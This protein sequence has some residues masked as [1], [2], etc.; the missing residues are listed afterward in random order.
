[1]Q[2]KIELVLISFLG[3]FLE[4]SFIRWL[5]AHIFSIAFFS[6]VILI[7]SFLGLGLGFLL[8]HSERDLF[9]LFS[10]ILAGSVCLVLFLTNIQVTLPAN[11]QTWL[12]SYYQGNRLYNISFLKA[13]ISQII[14]LIFI[15]T[16]VVFIPI[17]QKIGKLMQGFSPLYGYTMNILGSLLG[18]IVFGI[19]SFFYAPAYIWFAVVGFIIL[20]VSYKKR[21]FIV[22][23]LAMAAIVLIV[24]VTEKNILWSPY[25][26][27][28][29]RETD[30]K[31]VAVFI[32]KLFHQKAVNFE[33]EPYLYKK[34]MLPYEWF[35]PKRVLIIGS[36]TGND[37]WIAQRAGVDY[38][39]AVEIDPLIL[40]LG[41]KQHPQ[42]PY[43]SN[44]VK[45]F[46]DD[47]RS[48]MHR[49][50]EK[51]DMI[52]YGTL[53]SHATLSI[54]SSIRLDNYVYTQEALREAQNLLAPEG[55]VVLLF[56]VPTDWMNVRLLETVRS[57]FG[58]EDTRYLIM[59]EY[60]FNLMIIA[61]P[62]TKKAL[63]V[64]PNLSNLLSSLPPESNIIIP[65]DDW[66]YLYLTRRGI[67]RLYLITLIFLI[68]FSAA[69]IFIFSPLRQ[70]KIN[71]LFFFLGCGFLLLET[72]SVTTFS[73]LFGS[74]WLVNVVV[75][76]AILAIALLANWLV[77]IKQLE[78]PRWFLMGLILSLLF[79]YFF[80]ITSLL[81]LEFFIKILTAGVL[82]ALPILFTSL[83]F[84][85]VIKHTK[86]VGIALGSNLLGAVIGGFFEYTSMIWGLN[87]LYIFALG[88]Y[89]LAG[90]YLIRKDFNLLQKVFV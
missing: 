66:P 6:N 78:N 84:A 69:A 16:V 82:L 76:S 37:V 12:W 86:D 50:S 65:K 33:Q 48:F 88:W 68:C 29:L 2:Q 30:N 89:I 71:P 42:H 46:V 7:A 61:G 85:V 35:N 54:T 11:A 9:Y 41:Y 28:E 79:I 19:L 17:G 47:A 39:D 34:Y 74:T 90:F 57:V 24:G 26:A 49:V 3:L 64:N 60:L 22:N 58:S 10:Y 27:I 51:Y 67:P 14:G 13:S 70:A 83:V 15:L 80:P 72:K 45:V 53:D 8:L 36:G 32:N 75:F 20:S 63:S 23:L 55:V 62:G 81:R 56:S 1:M 40:N 52:V 44:R 5:P 38:I 4:L 18:V 25:Y 77:K 87:A 21:G 59:D 73:L 31:G 43:D